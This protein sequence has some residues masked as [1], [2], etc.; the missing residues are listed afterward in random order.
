MKIDKKSLKRIVKVLLN[1]VPKE[2]AALIKVSDDLTL[3]QEIYRKDKDFRNFILNP[4]APYEDKKKIIDSLSEKAGLDPVVK[5]AL[6]YIVKTNKGNLL[7]IIGDEF[8]FEVEKF[9]ATVKGEIITAYPID[10]E[11]INSVKEVVE[12]KLGK[13]VEF[14]IKQD[15]SIIGGIIVKAGSYILDS[16][17]KTYLQKLEQQLTAF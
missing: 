8:R 1:K 15:P 17:L 6:E 14:D 7:K 10:E 11:T 13:K 2:E 16:S 4:S 5:E 12:K 3:I 9:F